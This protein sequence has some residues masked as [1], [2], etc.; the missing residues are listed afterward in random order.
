ML[1]LSQVNGTLKSTFDQT[2]RI[3][4]S[5]AG[6]TTISDFL[7]LRRS[8]KTFIPYHLVFF[9]PLSCVCDDCTWSVCVVALSPAQGERQ[10]AAAFHRGRNTGHSVFNYHYLH[11]SLP[12]W[13]FVS[14]SLSTSWQRHVVSR[15]SSSS[16]AES[17]LGLGSAKCSLVA[18]TK[19]A[20]VVK[21]IWV[22][23]GPV[24]WGTSVLYSSRQTEHE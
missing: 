20:P 10:A 6:F 12:S 21:D 17:S 19:R 18:R 1:G 23:D 16:L 3:K 9:D 8:F 13:S 5:L 24:V 22:I 2:L 15:V 4:N 7:V 14:L 11:G